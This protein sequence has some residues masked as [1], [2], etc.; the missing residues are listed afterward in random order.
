MKLLR[1]RLAG[2]ASAAIVLALS[3]AL[4]AGPAAAQVYFGSGSM[5][6]EGGPV[7][8]WVTIRAQGGE[9]AWEAC[10]RVYQRDVYQ[11]VPTSGGR[12]RCRID[13]TRIYGPG[14]VRQ[15]FNRR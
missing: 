12:V 9:G 15:N 1:S 10:R 14:E 4:P 2:A 5:L 11:A 13:H 8:I 6:D 3:A 7:T